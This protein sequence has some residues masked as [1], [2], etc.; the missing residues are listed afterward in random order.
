MDV[1]IP[2]VDNTVEDRDHSVNPSTVVDDTSSPQS[3]EEALAH[4]DEVV[5]LGERQS[6][7]K[8]VEIEQFFNSYALPLLPCERSAVLALW[9]RSRELGEDS[10]EIA[11]VIPCAGA[12]KSE[13][14]LLMKHL[15]R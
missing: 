5:F 10:E 3:H 6:P 4:D 8:D 7:S 15:F 11:L 13:V 9:E 14:Y 2:H 12:A 1:A